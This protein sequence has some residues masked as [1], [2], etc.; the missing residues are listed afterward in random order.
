L[1]IPLQGPAFDNFINSLNVDKTKNEYKRLLLDFAKYRKVKTLD[2]LLEG[3]ATELKN[4]ITKYLTFLKS[5]GLSAGTR[6][7]AAAS[8]RHFYNMNDVVLNWD[9]IRKFVG[10]D[11][12]KRVDREYSLDEI[13]KILDA[14]D[15]KYKAII[16]LMFSSS[17]RIG[18]L[19]TMQYG[20]LTKMKGHDIFKVTVYA[21]TRSEY[22][23]FC[24]PE[25]FKAIKEY[26]SLRER[27]GEV[28]KPASP[29]WR[30][31]FD[32]EDLDQVKNPTFLSHDAIKS[33]IRS[34]LIRTG[35]AQYQ[36]LDNKN[37]AGKR[38]NEVMAAHGMRKTAYTVMGRSHMDPEIRELLVGHKIGVRATYLKYTVE[39]TLAEY[40]RALDNLT[41]H[42]E[43][44]LL[45]QVDEFKKQERDI[46]ELK[47]IVQNDGA[48]IAHLEEEMKSVE[49]KTR[50]QVEQEAKTAIDEY[51]KGADSKVLKLIDPM[52]KENAR[53][54]AIE[55]QHIQ[56]T[57]A[58]KDLHEK[59]KG[60][61]NKL[62]AFRSEIHDENKF[63]DK[64]LKEVGEN[65]T[66][67]SRRKV[68]R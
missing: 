43:N 53:L 29:L 41:V 40:L 56:D 20:D 18:S 3:E 65:E 5:K 11:D 2:Q 22:Y 27:F 39:D 16:L 63:V 26:L 19:H 60:M 15:I 23:T 66:N 33:K 50:Q 67:R 13:A 14:A 10:E 17:L 49:I 34:L 28:L 21:R 7:I 25:A 36:K 6:N 44:R 4:H 46:Q 68:K 37:T 64:V 9:S 55:K 45:A 52:I 32:P 1:D 54:K 24:T 38:R 57:N 59:V 31:D 51:F 62:D 47:E 8:L 48:Y 12:T 58:I 42:A 61:G 30:N 35:V